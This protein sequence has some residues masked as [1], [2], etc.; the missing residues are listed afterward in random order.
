MTAYYNDIDLNA[1][2]WLEQLIELGCIAPGNVDNRSIVDV[3][4]AELESY[5]Q[6]HFFAGIG[7]WSYA[8][9][10]A[11]WADNMP[12]VTG[13][14]PC[15]PFSAAGQRKGSDDNRDLWWAMFWHIR[16]LQP[17]AVFGEQVASVDGLEWWDAV[18]ADLE[19]ADYATAAFD[20]PA[21]GVGAPHVRQRLFWVA[22]AN[23]KRTQRRL[24]KSKADNS[25]DKSSIHSSVARLSCSN[26]VSRLGNTIS[27]ERRE[28]F[29]AGVDHFRQEGQRNQSPNYAEQ[30]SSFA[31]SEFN[32]VECFDGKTR[33]TKPSIPPMAYGITPDLVQSSDTRIQ[34]EE[35]LEAATMR[36]KGYGNA[37]VAPLAT[38]FVKAAM[39]IIHNKASP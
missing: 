17:S 18:S 39:E 5:D 36:L 15:Q 10:Q 35:T 26:S 14:C 1:C 24:H 16:Q 11:G 27:S 38:A 7:V 31:A 6:V 33:P 23:G 20:L 28:V 4:P 8:L 34:T 25:K 9:R 12:V 3:T 13:S 2:A 30:S 21:A 32:W 22:H 37:I 19:A 29:A